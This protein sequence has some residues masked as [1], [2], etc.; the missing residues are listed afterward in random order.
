MAYHRISAIPAALLV[1]LA[2]LTFAAIPA[3]AQTPA[4]CSEP[5][6]LAPG[7][8]AY[9]R[10]GVFI[11]NLPSVSGGQLE[12]Y[13]RSYTLLV[14]GGP[15]CADGYNWWQVEGPGNPGWVAEGTPDFVLLFP[16]DDL[17]LP[18][19]CPQ[20]VP[21][22][23]GV[24]VRVIDGL[25]VRQDPS[26]SGRVLGSVAADTVLTITGDAVCANSINWWPVQVPF[27]SSNELIN[28][29]IAEGQFGEPFVSLDL[30]E[31]PTPIPCAPP[32][33]RLDV[34][35][36]AVVVYENFEAK[37]L[38]A[39]PGLNAP[40]IEELLDGV[41]VDITGGP[42]CADGLNWW[43][44]AVVGASGVSGWLAE[45]A[46]YTVG[47]WLRPIEFFEQEPPTGLAPGQ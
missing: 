24:S 44:V 46:P 16:A 45:G 15:V 23:P 21:I 18:E 47:Y 19:T 11:R 4:A 41:A 6:P 25:R 9:N 30:V 29:W 37:N 42:V 38:R 34:G 26:L 31:V 10:P 43:Q 20:I 13:N 5:L 12:Y 8:Y 33:R 27:G 28:G 22:T 39:E 35:I 3:A 14:T 32:Y 7:M 2:L 36:R 40:I 17:N 1:L